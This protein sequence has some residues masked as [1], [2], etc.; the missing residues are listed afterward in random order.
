[1][2]KKI[3]LVGGCSFATDYVSF[4]NQRYVNHNRPVILKNG[5]HSTEKHEYIKPFKIWPQ[6]IADDLNLSMMNTAEKGIGNWGIYSKT[7]DALFQNIST[8]KQVIVQWSRWDRQDLEVEWAQRS[9]KVENN[10]MIPDQKSIHKISYPKDGAKSLWLKFNSITKSE[11]AGAHIPDLLEAYKK[12]NI[13]NLKNFVMKF[14]R[15]A[16]SMQ[17]VCDNL[18]ISCIQLQGTNPLHVGYLQDIYQV[19][20]SEIRNKFIED[21]YMSHYFDKI[22][23]K[24]FIGWPLLPEMGGFSLF[25]K[26]EAEDFISENDEH[27]NHKG[28]QKFIN[29]IRNHLNNA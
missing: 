29:I 13:F 7:L 25:D 26:L 1:M 4:L 11:T 21:V 5:E 18:G 28:N 23:P 10:Q 22:D 12:N 2:D 19:S 14:Y 27:P 3:C 17:S 8:V 16:I 15:L 20:W 9:T 6:Q 24:K